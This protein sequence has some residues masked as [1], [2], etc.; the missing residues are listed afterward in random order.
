MFLLAPSGNF[1]MNT[2]VEKNIINIIKTIPNKYFKGEVA[3]MGTCLI[4]KLVIQGLRFTP[5]WGNFIPHAA[6]KSSHATTRDSQC[7]SKDQAQPNKQIKVN[8]NKKFS[9]K[10]TFKKR[11]CLYDAFNY[12]EGNFGVGRN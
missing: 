9:W 2:E 10:I 8:T 6:I 11:N 7:R 4:V 5:W 1:G 12:L 3:I